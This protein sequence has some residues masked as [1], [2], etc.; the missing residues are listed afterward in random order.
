MARRVPRGEKF[1]RSTADQSSVVLNPL[2]DCK[3]IL[4]LSSIIHLVTISVHYFVFMIS[5]ADVVS[6]GFR[7]CVN[8]EKMKSVGEL[9]LIL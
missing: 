5:I 7:N 3:V 2:V 8:C 6:L 4:S 1:Q 9:L